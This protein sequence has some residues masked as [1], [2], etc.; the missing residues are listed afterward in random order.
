VFLFRK[1]VTWMVVVS[2]YET[3]EYEEEEESISCHDEIKTFA[4]ILIFHRVMTH[5]MH[6]IPYQRK[7]D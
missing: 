7:I 1:V 3:K 4:S 6:Y 2:F 5:I